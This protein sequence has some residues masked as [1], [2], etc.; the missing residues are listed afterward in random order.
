MLRQFPIAALSLC[1]VFG[2]SSGHHRTDWNP[3]VR[4]FDLSASEIEIHVDG[5]SPSHSYGLG[6]HTLPGRPNFVANEVTLAGFG[7]G[8]FGI[9]SSFRDLDADEFA[10]T[11]PVFRF[12]PKL[13]PGSQLLL[14]VAVPRGT[15]VRVFRDGRLVAQGTPEPSLLVCD[16]RSVPHLVEGRQSVLSAMIFPRGSFSGPDARLLKR[17]ARWIAPVSLLRDHLRIY[18]DP[19]IPASAIPPGPL[20][21][22][23]RVEIDG[24][25]AVTAA[26]PIGL[27]EDLRTPLIAA[28]QRWRF[29]PFKAEEQVQKVLGTVPIF[30]GPQRELLVGISPQMARAR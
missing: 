2:Q 7:P 8:G 29:R 20:A 22:S 11:L 21:G 16:D 25:G 14:Y 17:D 19:E 27:P 26:E 9:P 28:A 30:I 23:L 15:R 24:Q 6:V 4:F 18:V 12:F 13:K 1:G 3:R 5:V 10:D